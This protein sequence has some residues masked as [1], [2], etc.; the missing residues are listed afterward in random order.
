ML[1]QTRPCC[2]L[3]CHL[4]AP[5]GFF[6]PGNSTNF[7]GE[8]GSVTAL[9]CVCNE[10]QAA[11]PAWAPLCA[12][13]CFNSPWLFLNTNRCLFVFSISMSHSFSK[14][15]G[16]QDFDLICIV[17]IWENLGGFEGVTPA[18]DAGRTFPSSFFFLSNQK[19]SFCLQ[20]Q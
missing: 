19:N 12:L 18:T 15:Y 4:A 1:K 5:R 11:L 9:G 8:K 7:A 6:P 14:P 3:H 20:K 2:C 10:R 17:Q 16:T 13:I